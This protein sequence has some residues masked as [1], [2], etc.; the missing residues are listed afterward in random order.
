MNPDR[1]V[2]G[3]PLDLEFAGPR[4][5]LVDQVWRTA[6]WLA[7]LEFPLIAWR[8]ADVG[9]HVQLMLHVA[10]AALTVVVAVLRKRL[11]YGLK[12]TLVVLATFGV[13][14]SG[15]LSLG[16]VG[17]GLLW[18]ALSV[19]LASVLYSLRIGV[20]VAA[21]SSAAMLAAGFG[22]VSG[23][24]TRPFD[25]NAHAISA[26]GWL[27]YLAV[28]IVALLVL[29]YA[30]GGF[31]QAVLQLLARLHAQRDQL[32]ILAS[33]DPLTGLPALQLATDRLQMA[34]NSAARSGSKVALLFIDLD[35]FKAVN[36]AH[37]H[38]AG[39]QVLKQVAR[40]LQGA[41]RAD[42]TVAR[43]GGDEFIVVL[44]GLLDADAVRP[45]ASKLIAEVSRP[46]EVAGATV[47]VGASI[48]IAMYPDHA[49]GIAGLKRLADAAM[50]QAKRSG[51]NRFVFAQPETPPAV[52]PT[53]A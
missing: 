14:T 4:R 42:D 2:P 11:P 34:L 12:S 32:A 39:D 10:F 20:I 50:Y 9:W 26:S 28:T 6:G 36:D 1:G 23:R 49:G 29:L 22:F 37:G 16:M 43:V 52:S 27:D 15:L 13:G 53:S 38:E 17:A 5:V 25:L 35:G 31:Q 44:G 45:A 47:T 48:G 46:F 8:V 51:K 41:V 21:L 7:M 3:D 19:G 40:R 30:I 24:L 18:I 33:H